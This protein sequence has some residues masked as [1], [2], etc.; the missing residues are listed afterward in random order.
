MYEKE[1]IDLIKSEVA[2]MGTIDENRPRVRP[3]KPYIDHEGHIWLFS[4]YDS[5]KVAN[6]LQNPRIELC[7]LGQEQQVL[8]IYGR[9]KDETKSG[10]PAF[11]VV[12]D[13]MLNEIPEMKHYFKDKNQDT[14]I[15]YRLIVHD[16]RYTKA[17]CELTTRINLPMEHDPDIELAMCQGGFCLEP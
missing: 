13:I 15:I 5:K 14:L 17:D 1:V 2:F 12:R 7:F 10:S 16:I 9:I 3:M 8:N 11:Q 6:L 4:R